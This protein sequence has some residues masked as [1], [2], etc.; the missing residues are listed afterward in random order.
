MDFLF[1]LFKI[2]IPSGIIFVTVYFMLKQFFDG[3][4]RLKKL[5]LRKAGQKDI[6]PMKMQ[7][8]E[9]LILFLERISPNNLVMRTQKPS[10]TARAQQAEML[11][12]IREEFDH[13]LTQ[14]LYISSEAWALVKRA[15]EEVIRLVN[16]AASKMEEETMS[17]E[18]SKQILAMTAQLEHIPTKVAIEGLK[19]EFR[20]YF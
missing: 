8:Y 18:L 10:L 16:I 20:S 5:E 7:A 15:K 14:Q 6:N 3:Q 19:K 12:A 4:E 9:R 1:E 17:V 11:K 13:N 2:L